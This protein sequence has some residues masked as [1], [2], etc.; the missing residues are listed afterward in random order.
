MSS[1]VIHLPRPRRARP[2]ASP[3]A[4]FMRVGWNDHRELLDLMATG[5]R[6][7]S[8]FVVQAQYVERHKDLMVEARNRGFDLVLDPKTHAMGF[9]GGH[10]EKL[11]ELPWGSPRHHTLSDFEGSQG[12]QKAEQ[13]VG[14]AI[15]HGFTH[16]LGPSHVLV[17]PN[18]PW[19]RRDREMM[20]W[21]YEEIAASGMD[22]DLI[23]SLA[24][25]MDIPRKPN[26]RDALINAAN[27]VPCDAV[28][29]K[30]GNFGDDATGEKTAAYIEACQYFHARGIPLIGDQVGGLPGL[31]LLAFGAVGGIAHG[32]TKEQSFK[33]ATWR[34]L[35]GPVSG[36]MPHRVYFPQLDML[37]K[38]EVASTLF[39]ASSRIRAHL[40]C[41]D[42]HCCA[43]GFQDMLAHPARHAL[44]QRAREVE[45]LS[46]TPH[47]VR[48]HRYL[49]ELVRPV[50]DEIAAIAGFAGLDARLRQSFARKQQR[51]SRFRLAMAHLAAANL[52]RSV[53]VSP[54]PCAART[55]RGRR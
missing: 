21:T 51:M 50:S 53:A 31:G 17:G 5:A 18:D 43:H 13:I 44:Y 39:S 29:L 52:P 37:L 38:R 41:R 22:I 23:H 16:L 24:V 20:Q 40:G 4:L 49:D 9:P 55:G 7:V 25:P 11:A 54:P 47:A 35:P 27:D 45:R 10:T 12:R 46:E 48:A 2:S 15:F 8:G 28:W 6:G 19:L 42:T 26:E 14:M 30:T 3:L 34:R 32:V 36:G 1:N 33:P